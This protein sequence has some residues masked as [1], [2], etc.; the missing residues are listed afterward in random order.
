MQKKVFTLW[1]GEVYQA[2][3]KDELKEDLYKE[4]QS[5]RKLLL[6]LEILF[7]TQIP[8]TIP[9]ENV[10]KALDILK[11]PS[12]EVEPQQIVEGHIAATLKLIW[13]IIEQVL[14]KILF[15]I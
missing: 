13:I 3:K 14:C 6:L 2:A 1:I 10:E 8:R 4:F 12:S 7:K 5:G 15:K 11:V 9:L